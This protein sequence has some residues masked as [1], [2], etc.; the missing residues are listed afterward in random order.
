MVSFILPRKDPQYPLPL[1]GQKLHRTL[2]LLRSS[3]TLFLSGP[4]CNGPQFLHSFRTKIVE[5]PPPL[6]KK[7]NM[8]NKQK[9]CA[10]QSNC[11]CSRSMQLST[12]LHL[13]REDDFQLTLSVPLIWSSVMIAVPR[14]SLKV[15]WR[16]E[17][18]VYQLLLNGSRQSS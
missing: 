7:V 2:P 13:S 5:P 6:P 17:T 15:T 11:P 8:I 14:P 10:I 3:W 12:Q 18:R 4:I 1:G 9:T 16:R